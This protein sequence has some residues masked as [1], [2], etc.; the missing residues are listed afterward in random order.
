MPINS[1]YL[2]NYFAYIEMHTAIAFIN[3]TQYAL[4]NT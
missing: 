4:Q 1:L 2:L 3:E